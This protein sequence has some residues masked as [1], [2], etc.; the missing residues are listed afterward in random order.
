MRFVLRCRQEGEQTALGSSDTDPYQNP[1]PSKAHSA[2]RPPAHPGLLSVNVPVHSDAPT[3]KVAS[4]F[5]AN[6]KSYAE[7]RC[8]ELFS[9]LWTGL[10]S[11]QGRFSYFNGI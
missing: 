2:S 6:S 9:K 7:V 3:Q 4:P 1:N 8:P 11:C 5:A 10:G